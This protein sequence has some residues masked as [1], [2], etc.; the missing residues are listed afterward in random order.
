MSNTSIILW[1]VYAKTKPKETNTYLVTTDDKKVLFLWYVIEPDF[2]TWY[3]GED[4]EY[5]DIKFPGWFEADLEL[6]EVS[7]IECYRIDDEDVIEWA[8]LPNRKE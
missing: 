6:W 5:A 1:N 2:F 3:D 8:E 4:E 7:D